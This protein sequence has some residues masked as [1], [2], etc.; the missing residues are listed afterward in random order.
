MTVYSLLK[1]KIK[2][3]GERLR[4]CPNIDCNQLYQ[5][6]GNLLRCFH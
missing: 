1:I 6:F 5:Y 3:V 2:E 4:I